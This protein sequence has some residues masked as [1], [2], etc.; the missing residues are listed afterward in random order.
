MSWGILGNSLAIIRPSSPLQGKTDASKFDHVKSR[1]LA[2]RTQFTNQKAFALNVTT[3]FC[4]TVANLIVQ[5]VVLCP[6]CAPATPAVSSELEQDQPFG[7]VVPGVIVTVLAPVLAVHL[8]DPDHAPPVCAL[9]VPHDPVPESPAAEP[10]AINPLLK[11]LF[12]SVC[13]A[14]APTK[15]S[16]EPKSGM[17]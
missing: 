7:A 9:M 17:V 13:I 4:V 8:N 14:A 11:V 12:E 5:V 16:L 3:S 10:P 1:R 2:E 6:N 15:L